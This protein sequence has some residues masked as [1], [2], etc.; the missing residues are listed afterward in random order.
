MVRRILI[1]GVGGMLGRDLVDAAEGAGMD[2][3]GLT[4]SD[5]DVTDPAAV[6]DA[7]RQARPDVAINCAAWTDVDGAESAIEEALA[8]NGTG[9]GNVARAA[10]ACGAWTIHLSTDY[11]FDGTKA[12]PYVESDAPR[13]LSAYGRSKLAG[14]LE[15]ARN[16]PDRHTVVRASWLFGPHGR[17][18]PSTILRLCGERDQLA[19]VDDQVGCPTF[20]GHL[21]P[22]L[23]ELVRRGAPVGVIHM[24]GSGSCSWFELAGRVVEVAGLNCQ[25]TRARTEDMARPAARPAYSV[26]SSERQVAPPLPHWHRGVEEFM[27]V[28]V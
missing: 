24:A 10:G 11:V 22:A 5:L 16:A 27:A 7:L 20:T 26:L 4:R 18:F 2:V 19:V 13:P 25:L 1:T 21:A 3:V 12:G 28:R 15:V 9:A 23:V 17:C 8:T 14:E 6:D